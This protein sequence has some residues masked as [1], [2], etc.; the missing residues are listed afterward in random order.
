MYLLDSQQYDIE[1]LVGAVIRDSDTDPAYSA[2]TAANL[3]KC[4]IKVMQ[5]ITDDF[6][7]NDIESY[8]QKNHF[9]SEEYHVF[10]DKY[11]K[12]TSYYRSQIF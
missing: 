10:M 1:E 4:Y 6:Y 2:V 5:E 11:H 12:E 3:I 9:T 7:C 8:F